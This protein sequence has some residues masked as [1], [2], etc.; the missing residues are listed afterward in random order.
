[1]TRS[2]EEVKNIVENMGYK[3]LEERS[4]EKK[5]RIII[6]DE[7]GYKYDIYFTNFIRGHI[8]DFVSKNNPFSLENIIIWI[9][10]KNKPF[11]LRKSNVYKGAREKLLFQCV[12]DFCGEVFETDWNHI[13]SR[14]FGCPFCSGRKV[15]KNNNLEHLRPDLSKEWDYDKNE[16]TP[17]EYVIGSH[18]K[19][20]WKCSKCGNSWKTTITHRSCDG[21]GCPKCSDSQRESVIANN[22]KDYVAKKYN[23]KSEYKILRNPKT[24]YYLPFDI[25][26]PYGDNPELN[27]F[28]IEIHGEQ[29]YKMCHFHKMKSKRNNTTPEE[30]YD[31]QKKKDTLKKFF[32]KKNGTYIEVNLIKI[33]TLDEALD[34][35]ENKLKKEL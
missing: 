9:K 29:H 7:N 4:D 13:Y 26:I 6:K 16:K 20:Y 25:Y 34:Y 17:K 11:E 28:Y 22:L 14:D 33:K 19:V 8:P 27:G 21:T 23:S 1:M 32:A 24:G 3:L 35:V 2:T 5:K 10:N 30:E 15:G 31:Y 12:K 18:E